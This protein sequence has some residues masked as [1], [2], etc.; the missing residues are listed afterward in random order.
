[1]AVTGGKIAHSPTVSLALLRTYNTLAL[2][3]LSGSLGPETHGI[4]LSTGEVSRLLLGE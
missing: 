4:P 1:M 3:V 2:A